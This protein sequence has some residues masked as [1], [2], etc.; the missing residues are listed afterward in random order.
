MRYAFLAF[1]LLAFA[2]LAVG[3]DEAVPTS[4]D[5]VTAVADAQGTFAQHPVKTDTK[6]CAVGQTVTWDGDIWVCTD[7]PSA[8]VAGWE[9]QKRRCTVNP[10]QTLGCRATCNPGK[11]ILGGGYSFWPVQPAK[12]DIEIPTD[13]P[14]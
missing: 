11:K 7:L 3:C 1:I 8:A 10:G 14:V 12:G 6:T 9:F 5:A 4:P 13:K 2:A